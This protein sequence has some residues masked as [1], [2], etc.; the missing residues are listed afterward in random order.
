M[1]LYYTCQGFTE[2]LTDWLY[3]QTKMWLEEMEL[4]ERVFLNLYAFIVFKLL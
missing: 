2:T 1:F 4:G 3:K